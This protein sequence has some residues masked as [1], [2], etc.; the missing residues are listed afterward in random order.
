MPKISDKTAQKL[1]IITSWLN[2][3]YAQDTNL[4]KLLMDAGFTA[5][6]IKS[7]QQEHLREFLEAAMSLASTYNDLADLRRNQ[8]M[9]RYHDLIG[10]AD[11]FAA[12]GSRV[13]VS[14]E[15]IKQLLNKKPNLY[16]DPKRKSQFKTD[17]ASIARGIL[18]RA[19]ENS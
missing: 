2:D 4:D 8:L 6:E 10:T 14:P 9:V 3:V 11:S 13:G 7:L 5:A 1:L 19:N 12:I 17:F 18:D 16:P 15:R